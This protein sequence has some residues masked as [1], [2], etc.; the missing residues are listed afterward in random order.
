MR[1]LHCG[2]SVLIGRQ[3]C[4]LCC[5]PRVQ[6]NAV[7]DGGTDGIDQPRVL[8]LPGRPLLRWQ[9]H[10]DA[11][12]R[13]LRR[14]SR[15][16]RVL[17]LQRRIVRD[18]GERVVQPVRVR[19]VLRGR[20][21]VCAGVHRVAHVPRGPGPDDGGHVDDGSRVL[22]VRGRHELVGRERRRAL[23]RCDDVHDQRVGVEEADG[24]IEPRVLDAPG[25]VPGGSV[26]V[27]GSDEHQRPR[28][29]GLPGVRL[30]GLRVGRSGRLVGPP[31]RVVSCGP[32]VRRQ[33]NHDSVRRGPL[34]GLGRRKLQRV[35]RGLRVV[36][37]EC[38]VRPV[39]GGLVCGC[40]ER[41]VHAVL[42]RHIFGGHRE[43]LY[44]VA[45]VCAGRG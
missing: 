11:V 27:R 39:C 44:A 45:D 34:R 30:V 36:V 29:Q 6:C 16:R 26:H 10:G 13:R 19:H 8:G 17:H 21:D 24:D 7:R 41:R 9:R 38:V 1:D 33:R 32:R 35:W 37:G 22:G 14:R 15:D 43:Q 5:C 20:R 28:V 12:Q 42:E 3:W 31:V 4:T 40:C 23:L 25:S 2:A 18:G